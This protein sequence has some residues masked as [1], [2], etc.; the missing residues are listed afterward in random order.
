VPL[1]A[2]QL[3]DV[4][5]DKRHREARTGWLTIGTILAFLGVTVAGGFL[6]GDFVS[7][8]LGVVG[9]AAGIGGVYFLAKAVRGWN[10][11]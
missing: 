4:V 2:A 8:M 5:A 9:I 10:R 7:P 1:T 11:P 6:A 3:E